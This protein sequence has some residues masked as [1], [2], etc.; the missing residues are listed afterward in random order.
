[1][2][3]T[4]ARP[5][6]VRSVLLTLATA[7]A[8]AVSG[9]SAAPALAANA[10]SPTAHHSGH[11]A[12][13]HHK[14]HHGK[15]HVKHHRKHHHKNHGAKRHHHKH[16]S[17]SGRGVAMRALHVAATK[18]GDPYVYGAAGPGA[19]DCS[20]LTSFSYRLA[21]RT[22]PR[23]SAAQ[24]GATRRIPASAARP[25]DLVFFSSGG[26]VYHVGFYAGHHQ[27]LHAPH[28]GARVRTERIWTSSVS[29]GRVG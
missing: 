11:H 26:R 2:S 7:A 12:K 23:T 8:L 10:A 19:F 17:P 13:H 24:R 15:Q 9:F 1:M 20:G 4:P 3:P 22:I 28:T 25:G 18:K 27:V 16:A 21:G 14:H 29:Y 5:R 6:A